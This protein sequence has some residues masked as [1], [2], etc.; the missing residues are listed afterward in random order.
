MAFGPS[1]GLLVLDSNRRYFPDIRAD[2]I[3]GDLRCRFCSRSR[4]K[5]HQIYPSSPISPASLDNSIRD[6]RRLGLGFVELTLISNEP[7]IMRSATHS[8][9][10]RFVAKM[11]HGSRNGDV[12]QKMSASLAGIA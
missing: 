7:V 10:R 3:S 4:R 8:S 2:N 1:A 11:I 12:E 6:D 5:S 9:D